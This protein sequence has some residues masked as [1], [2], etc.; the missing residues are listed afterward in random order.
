MERKFS[1]AA[2]NFLEQ[3]EGLFFDFKKT[4]GLQAF[5]LNKQG[6]LVTKLEG[7]QEVC[8]LILATEEG[9]TRCKDCFKMGFLLAKNQRTSVFT[10]CYANFTICFFP[11]IIGNSLVGLMIVCGGRYDRGENEEE[12][13][14]KFISLIGE[15]EIIDKEY[16][17]E[18]LK[19]TKII[20]EEEFKKEAEKLKKLIDILTEN[21]KTPLLEILG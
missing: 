4:T 16:F 19:R 6:E 18:K 1:E 2:Q 17:F 14:K 21:V 9:K 20:T 8:K 10:E 11:V 15:L 13:K 5:L 7:V 12:L 3:L